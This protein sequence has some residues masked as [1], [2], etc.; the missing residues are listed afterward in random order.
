MLFEACEHDSDV[1]KWRPREKSNGNVFRMGVAMGKI[2]RRVV[3]AVVII[4]AIVLVGRVV[5][6]EFN[7]SMEER[8]YDVAVAVC[9]KDVETVAAVASRKDVL[10]SADL[11]FEEYDRKYVRWTAVNKMEV[12][13]IYHPIENGAE[14][15]KKYSVYVHDDGYSCY[16]SVPERVL[17]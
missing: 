13:V 17:E 1:Q 10:S 2:I 9:K 15:E 3:F 5:Y 16:P 7:K 8:A 6:K 11:V 12:Q 4:A 14:K